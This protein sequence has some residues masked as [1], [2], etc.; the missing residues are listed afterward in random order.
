MLWLSI[1]LSDFAGIRFLEILFSIWC[2]CCLY[3]DY[4]LEKLINLCWIL[5][6]F[7]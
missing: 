2:L 3:A 5:I 6:F 4:M 7:N 1:Y